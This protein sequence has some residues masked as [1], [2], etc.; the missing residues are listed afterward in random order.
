LTHSKWKA[1]VGVTSDSFDGMQGT[2]VFATTLLAK[3]EIFVD[4]I[5]RQL[6][7]KKWFY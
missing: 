2:N 5:G 6:S 4:S 3:K 7:A 1:D